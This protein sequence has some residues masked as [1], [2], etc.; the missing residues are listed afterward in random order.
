MM[1]NNELYKRLKK[2]NNELINK[3][4]DINYEA[5]LEDGF[6]F[7]ITSC[8]LG[9][10]KNVELGIVKSLTH[11]LLL[12]NM[13]EYLSVSKYAKNL[14]DEKRKLYKY[15]YAIFEYVNYEKVYDE[16]L[17]GILSMH[18]FETN[19]LKAIE[20][21]KKLGYTEDDTVEIIKSALP[22]ACEPNLT[23]LKIINITYPKLSNYYKYLSM[24]IH[25]YY[26]G[27]EIEEDII[28]AVTNVIIDI[29]KLLVQ[30]ESMA[31]VMS[32][33]D[34]RKFIFSNIKYDTNYCL[35]L[36]NCSDDISKNLNEL[37]KIF[38]DICNSKNELN[39]VGKFLINYSGMLH[40]INDDSQMGY[41]ELVKMKFKTMIEYISC[42][43]FIYFQ[44]F[45]QNHINLKLFEYHTLLKRNHNLGAKY[46]ENLLS[47]AYNF[48][49]KSFN[50]QMP[51]EKFK[52]KFK[53]TTGYTI[54]REGEVLSLSDMVNKFLKIVNM[55][56]FLLSTAQMNYIESQM[57]SH[58]NGYLFY[59]NTG[60][61]EDDISSIQILEY[62]LIHVLQKMYHSF[63]I[64]KNESSKNKTL[65]NAIRNRIKK[66]KKEINKQNEIWKLGKIPKLF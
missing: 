46:D 56:K 31:F 47:E 26:Y 40:E 25:P 61:F 52:Y 10:I 18:D 48:Y 44:D 22:C 28:K 42:F 43:E 36:K 63:H 17:G 59:A 9:I 51:Y 37:A 14:S 66:I 39:I 11:I 55:D 45:Y 16:S 12:R 53:Q 5:T 27:L 34:E 19:Y 35:E 1:D 2:I 54:N 21:F 64:F 38:Y 62:S 3:S 65:S 23:Y 32:F 41:S 7:S 29:L 50:V 57:L 24:Y 49:N 13:I 33:N 30:H 6:L 4:N 58:G 15:Q 8:G 60:I 20:E